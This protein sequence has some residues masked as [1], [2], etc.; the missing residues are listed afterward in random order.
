VKRQFAIIR[1]SGHRK[2]RIV[3]KHIATDSG[4]VISVFNRNVGRADLNFIVN[5]IPGFNPE[6]QTIHIADNQGKVIFEQRV[7]TVQK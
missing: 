6:E 2:G 4:I 3:E 1:Y 7:S 5:I